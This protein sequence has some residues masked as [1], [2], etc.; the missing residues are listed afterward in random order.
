MQAGCA[1]SQQVSTL[2]LRDAE[3]CTLQPL[4]PLGIERR[5]EPPWRRG[6]ARHCSSDCYPLTNVSPCGRLR[7]ATA[8]AHDRVRQWYRSSV[9]IDSW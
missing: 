1:F 3:A 5:H 8:T 7:L 9:H 6:L 4:L 2:H